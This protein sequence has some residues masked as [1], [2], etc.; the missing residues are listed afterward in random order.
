MLNLNSN[1]LGQ[2]FTVTDPNTEYVCV[3]YGYSGTF[4]IIGAYNNV[5]NNEYTL[6]SFKITDVKFKGLAT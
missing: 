3:G 5:P 4:V 1:L 2:K 6:K